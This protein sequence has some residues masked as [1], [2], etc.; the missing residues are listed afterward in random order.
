MSSRPAVQA[1]PEV[2]IFTDI[3]PDVSLD[4]RAAPSARFSSAS[5]ETPWCQ[6]RDDFSGGEATEG[7]WWNFPCFGL[8]GNL[9]SH[10]CLLL[11]AQSKAAQTYEAA[12]SKAAQR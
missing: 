2:D 8:L 1:Q 4:C 6:R 10:Y 5:W 12:Q 3:A 7:Y 9:K 11:D